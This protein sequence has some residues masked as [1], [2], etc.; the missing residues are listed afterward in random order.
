MAT[1]INP[2]APTPSFE[3]D[4]R[5]VMNDALTKIFRR[6]ADMELALWEEAKKPLMGEVETLK[7]ELLELRTAIKKEKVKLARESLK[8]TIA[9]ANVELLD[10]WMNRM[11]MK[12]RRKAVG[13]NGVRYL[14]FLFCF[15]CVAVLL[16]VL[17]LH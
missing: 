10:E 5:Q 1:E 13:K 6:Y 17:L 7:N 14:R 12:S 11:E 16:V 3:E 4:I 9:S 15:V 8:K 2:A